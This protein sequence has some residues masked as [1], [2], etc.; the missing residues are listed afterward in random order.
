MFRKVKFVEDG[1]SEDKYITNLEIK[2]MPLYKV[3]EE[4]NKIP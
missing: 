3:I 4:K 2:L 1:E